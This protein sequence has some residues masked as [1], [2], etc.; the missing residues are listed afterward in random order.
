[1]VRVQSDHY[2]FQ[3]CGDCLGD[4]VPNG[5]CLTADP[6][7]DLRPMDIVSVVLRQTEEGPFSSFVN[8]IGADGYAGVCKLFL[9]ASRSPTG[10]EIYLVGQINPPVLSPIPAGAIEALHRVVDGQVPPAAAGRA[11]DETAAAIA[12]LLPFASTGRAA[13]PPINP[14]EEKTL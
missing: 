8:S 3:F 7:L 12:L 5:S 4:L 13:W 1:M 11:S 6:S 10:E 2:S 14:T 9:G